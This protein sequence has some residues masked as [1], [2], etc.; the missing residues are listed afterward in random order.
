MIVHDRYIRATQLIG[1][2]ELVE[3]AGGDA[4]SLLADAQIK[5][6]ALSEPDSLISYRAFGNLIEIASQE[7][8]RPSFGLEWTLATP[9]HFPNLGPLALLA[10]FVG[11][12]QE[13]IET[14]QQYWR[15]HTDAFVMDQLTDEK[16]GDVVMRYV[17]DTFA[18]PTRQLTEMV[19]GNVCCLARHVTG[20]VDQDPTLIRFQHS[21]PTD[22]SAHQRVFRC[23]IEFGAEH[24]EIVF[25]RKY[26]Q[27]PTN[28]NFKLFKP[29]VGYYIK[30][31]IQRI[32]LYDQSMAT[33]IAL[34]IPS[35]I[36]TGKCNI[37]FISESLG[38]TPKKLQRLLAAEGTA[39]SQILETVRGNMARQFLVESEAP[40]GRIAGLLDYSTTAPFSLAFKRWTG[41][42]PLEFRKDQRRLD[43]EKPILL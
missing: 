1:F 24:D 17:T 35:V 7:L 20:Y 15:F 21:K 13:W 8:S 18:F 16:T 25:D 28:G 22:T 10:N 36:G 4:L 30:S 41:K 43:T 3:Q 26:L 29:L 32:P 31:R 23:P 42:T 34:A 27:Y 14:G 11:T 9:A 19:F 6:K 33:T 2:Q 12:L 38:L 37:E 40:V 5:A 39:F